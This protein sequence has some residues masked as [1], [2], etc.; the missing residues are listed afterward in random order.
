MD[1][2]IV[3]L[4]LHDGSV[5][6]SKYIVVVELLTRASS[7]RRAVWWVSEITKRTP[8]SPSGSSYLIEC[9]LKQ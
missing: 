2:L 7:P 6:L 1:T 5:C 8:S 9:I 3:G 4:K